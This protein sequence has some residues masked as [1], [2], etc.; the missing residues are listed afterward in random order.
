MSNNN[1]VSKGSKF[2]LLN[3]YGADSLAEMD[4][5][6]NTY[7]QINHFMRD[8]SYNDNK[9]TCLKIIGHNTAGLRR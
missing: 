1:I 2:D 5:M 9:S 4:G 6:F 3:K 8:Y 7:K